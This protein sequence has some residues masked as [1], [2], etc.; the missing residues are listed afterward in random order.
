MEE[1]TGVMNCVVVRMAPGRSI[2]T[3][4][5]QV[6]SSTPSQ[7]R[8]SGYLM[9]LI[10]DAIDAT[11]GSLYPCWEINVSAVIRNSEQCLDILEV[12]V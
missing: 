1:A 9:P 7:E 10:S 4:E 5:G 2:S 6:D 11:S 8:K 12:R 3:K